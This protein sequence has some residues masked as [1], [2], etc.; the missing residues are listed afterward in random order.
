MNIDVSETPAIELV[1]LDIAERFI[2]FGNHC[3]GKLLEQLQNQCAVGQATAGNL[4]HDK[5]M[6]DHVATFEQIGKQYIAPA[7]MVD[8]YRCVD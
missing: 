3:R 1:P 8:P 7:K 6:H 4:T 5:R 2:G